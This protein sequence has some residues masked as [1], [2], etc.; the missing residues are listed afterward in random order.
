[1]FWRN[2]RIPPGNYLESLSGDRKGEFSIRIN[3]QYLACFKMEDSGRTMLRLSIITDKVLY[4]A[5]PNR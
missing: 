2:H 1:M 4:H 5:H 3:D